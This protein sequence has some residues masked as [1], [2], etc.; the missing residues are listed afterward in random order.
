MSLATIE[1]L[2]EER[3]GLS[4]EM[5]G[6]E[7]IAAII[8]RRMEECHI[9]KTA[10]Y[11]AYLTTA[12]KEW[13]DLI[14]AVVVPET[15]FFRNDE[16]FT[17]L[18]QYLKTEWL[19]KNKN[20]PLRV[21]S[22]PCSTGEEP[23]SIAMTVTEAGVAPDRF[24]IEAVDISR[25]ALAKAQQGVYGPESFRRQ[26]ALAF[27][28]RYFKLAADGYRLA[29]TIRTAV[30]FSWGNLLDDQ[31]GAEAKPYHVIFCRNLL[32]YLGTAAKNK[33]IQVFE[34]L[35][36]DTGLLFVGHAE[37]GL[38]QAAD[39]V[40]VAMPGVFAYHRIGRGD[41]RQLCQQNR[42]PPR[43]ERR[44]QPR[45]EVKAAPAPAAPAEVPAKAVV[46]NPALPVVIEHR[47][48]PD[49]I[50]KTL[51]VARALADQGDLQKALAQCEKILAQNA[52]HVEANFLRGLI[53]QALNDHARAEE[54]FGKT[55]YLDPNHHEALYYLALLAEDRKDHD[56]T[57]RLWQR[58]RRI[59]QRAGNSKE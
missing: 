21:L 24:S 48:P 37:R 19:P 36:A 38:F 52:A 5:V 4:A 28:E 11:V 46:L 26:D 41:D 51:D 15:W 47:R 25:K 7:T 9:R 35:L 1:R 8:R 2:L 29:E 49:E 56:L 17:F 34:R 18:G 45:N 30:R 33:V 55:V 3:I 10:D 42:P 6:A 20:L 12:P 59:H 13:D 54:S 58:I 44:S 32:I 31:F 22:V 53:Y 39:L 23:Y 27:R 43:F 40:S 57:E 50:L 14:E 16:S